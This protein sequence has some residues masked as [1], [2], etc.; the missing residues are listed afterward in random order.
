MSDHNAK[1][2]DP[3]NNSTSNL[4]CGDDPMTGGA[5]SGQDDV[6]STYELTFILEAEKKGDFH[7][8]VAEVAKL[9][10]SRLGAPPHTLVEYDDTMYKKLTLTLKSTF[11]LNEFNLRHSL[12]IRPGL[13]TKPLYEPIPEKR[14]H[15]HWAPRSI[16]NEAIQVV[17]QKFGDVTEEVGHKKYVAKEDDDDITRM[18]E[19]VIL[20]D[21]ECKM[22]VKVGIPS[23]I[24]V[25]GHKIKI[26]Y[27]GQSRTCSRCYKFWSDCPGK[28]NSADCKKKDEALRKE[29]EEKGE[30]V[31]PKRTLADHMKKIESKLES[32]M[33][34]AAKREELGKID[35]SKAPRPTS[36]LITNVPVD[37]TLPQIMNLFKKN[38]TDIDNLDDKLVM[39]KG[40]PGTII[41]KDL[42]EID[43]ELVI[44]NI[45]GIYIKNKRLKAVPVQDFTPEKEK[46]EERENSSEN[47]EDEVQ[48]VEGAAGGVKTP[49]VKV[50]DKIQQY[51]E[52][53]TGSKV[54][55]R[56]TASGNT[57]MSKKTTRKDSAEGSPELAKNVTQRSRKSARK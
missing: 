51:E 36:I 38:N 49:V 26:L 20:P 17:L 35:Q 16:T 43:Y 42:D 27:E 15:I 55:E 10:Y 29:K 21:R 11:K 57:K 30:K 52:T 22:I 7:V 40:K 39:D 56:K 53:A 41:L 45:N 47:S 44:E 14:I 18:M 3:T 19:G 32:K 6:E 25:G 4:E 9:V 13:R 12:A 48:E 24:Q 31:K 54:Y 46:P 37:A 5:S 33:A 1:P 2:S 8:T 28:G 34:A 23:H 50:A